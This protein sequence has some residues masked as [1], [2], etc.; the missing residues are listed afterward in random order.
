LAARLDHDLVG[1]LVARRLLAV[2][3]LGAGFR[4]D[5]LVETAAERDVQ[6]LEPSADGQD[7]QSPIERNPHRRGL[8]GIP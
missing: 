7:R 8:D 1:G 3:E 2:A 4:A 5:V 6:Y